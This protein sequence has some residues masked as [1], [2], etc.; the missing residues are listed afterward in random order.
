MNAAE[1]ALEPDAEE[2]IDHEVPPL[3]WRDIRVLHAAALAPRVVRGFGIIRQRACLA[4]KHQVDVEPPRLQV[5]RDDE[6]IASVVA[7]AGEDQ[8]TAATGHDPACD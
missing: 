7:G 1:L 2:T 6:C 5:T 3:A 4:C 8:H